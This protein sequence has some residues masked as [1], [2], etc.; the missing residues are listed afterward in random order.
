MRAVR[1]AAT[2]AAAGAATAVT[3]L[4][5][6]GPALAAPEPAPAVPAVKVA[7]NPFKPGASL[8]VKISACDTAP[9]GGAGQVFT[10]A[11]KFRGNAGELWTAVAATKPSLT[12]G[13][14]YK[15][16]FTCKVGETTHKLTLTVNPSKEPGVKPAP[17]KFSFGYD[18]VELSTRKVI[19]GKSMTFT[20]T[21][22]TAVTITGNGFTTKALAV[23]TVRTGV[24]KAVGMFRS[25]TLPNPTVATVACKGHG[26]VKYS[27]KPGEAIKPGK[28][29]PQIP[30]GAP[31]TGDGSLSLHHEDGGSMTPALVGGG[32]AGALAVVGGG[33]VLL[34][35]RGA[36]REQS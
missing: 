25:G 9:A 36:G 24:F 20:I 6:A 14:S 23:K 30:A 27:T 34:R 15:A 7:P 17:Q 31:N 3:A 2:G 19:P 33:L 8:T 10:A 21:C 5:M 18:D 4:G 16:A 26:Y 32:S 29:S 22:P 11:P 28:K 12:P 1:L 13:H 35:R